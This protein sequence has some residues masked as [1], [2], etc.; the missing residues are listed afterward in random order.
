MQKHW[1]TRGVLVISLVSLFN[2]ASSEL[3]YP[4]LPIYLGTI[5][6]TGLWIGII[7]GVAEATAGLSKG[8]FGK[9][10]D[11]RGERLPFIRFGYLL[12]SLAKPLIVLFPNVAWALFMRASDR[13][14]KG[15]RTGARD[16]LLAHE[17]DPK[18]RGKVFGFHR[19]FD[20]VG[21]FIGPIIALWYMITHRGE[22][23]TNLF[24]IALIPGV[25]TMIVLMFLKDKHAEKK[26]AAKLPSWK[27]I[28]SYWKESNPNFRKTVGGFLL[29]AFVNSSDLFLLMAL[30]AVHT[31]LDNTYFGY[32]FSPEEM[33]ILYYILFNFFYAAL[34]Y[35]A[36]YFSDKF[37]PKSIFITGLI[38]FITTYSG[39]AWMMFIAPEKPPVYLPILLMG[40]YGMYA[41]LNDGI[42]RAW[43]S[44]IVP[45]NEK[46]SALGF[47]GGAG[48]IALMFACAGA[49]ALW[50]F[51]APWSVFAVTAVLVFIV[52]FYL[53]IFTKKPRNEED[54]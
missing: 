49:G 3:L 32:S 12:S 11:M 31:G 48:S 21:A 52:I 7:E 40:L 25:I 45:K 14:G 37:N 27:A 46:A 23:L 5:G 6:M 19:G 47:F 53:G 36:G 33:S 43:I 39:F 28:F 54:V 1:L 15:V 51:V 16:A 30:R 8:W 17:S 13:L 20:T 26:P 18:H 35:P 42:S 2:D 50:E 4:V 22:P 24:Y 10:S 34:S 41:A 38:C 44:N 9:W 29:F